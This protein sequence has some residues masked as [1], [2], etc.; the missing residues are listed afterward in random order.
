MTSR[1]VRWTLGNCRVPGFQCYRQCWAKSSLSA[2]PII[3]TMCVEA[4]PPVWSVRRLAPITSRVPKKKKKEKKK[5]VGCTDLGRRPPISLD[6]GVDCW[7]QWT[8]RLAANPA[9]PA[10]RATI[11]P[12]SRRISRDHSR[13]EPCSGPRFAHVRSASLHSSDSANMP[14]SLTP[15]HDH[16]DA[17]LPRRAGPGAGRR[18]KPARPNFVALLRSKR[19]CEAVIPDTEADETRF[20]PLPRSSMAGTTAR[21][22]TIGRCAG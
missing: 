8:R 4:C 21:A 9:S 3:K 6:F 2:P 7:C 16:R 11:S 18:K 15:R 1:M 12:T 5:P 14:A 17:Q 20:V 19:A 13:V 10:V 22:M